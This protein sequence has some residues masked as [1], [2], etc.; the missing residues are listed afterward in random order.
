MRLGLRRLLSI[1][2]YWLIRSEIEAGIGIVN[3]FGALAISLREIADAFII[4]SPFILDLALRVE[5]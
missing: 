2:G 3:T 4:K 1:W 5:N